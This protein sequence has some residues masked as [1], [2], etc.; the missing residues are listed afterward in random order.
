M[1]VMIQAVSAEEQLSASSSWR[2]PE[3]FQLMPSLLERLQLVPCHGCQ[4]TTDRPCS[5][6]ASFG[7][8]S[9]GTSL[10]Y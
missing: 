4:I 6:T 7:S 10:E 9:V 3:G 1:G 2:L 5:Q 8:G